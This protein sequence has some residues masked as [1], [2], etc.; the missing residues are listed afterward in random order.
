MLLDADTPLFS[1]ELARPL[2]LLSLAV[3]IGLLIAGSEYLPSS[4]WDVPLCFV[5]GI[6]AYVFAPW[7]FRQ[8]Y[9]FRWW[10][11]LPAAIAL[12]LT[13]DGSYTLYWWLKDFD[14]LSAF[15]PANYFYC[16]WLFWACGVV[17]NIDYAKFR[18]FDT[19]V[20][21]T[22]L[23]AKPKVGRKSPF[24]GFVC[25]A[26]LAAMISVQLAAI[27]FYRDYILLA[28]VFL[29]TAVV[30]GANYVEHEK[31]K[32][33]GLPKD[34]DSDGGIDYEEKSSSGCEYEV[35]GDFVLLIPN[36]AV[37]EV[38][39]LCEKFAEAGIR[40]QPGRYDHQQ[41]FSRFGRGGL[42]SRMYVWVH[43]D[44]VARARPIAER[45]L[46]VEV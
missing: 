26:F 8:V 25:A 15:R 41:A 44:D 30:L 34:F 22:N 39:P 33:P 24:L 19:S 40:F 32:E 45:L 38:D 21:M 10:K 2:R 12:W 4:D 9:Y 5:M 29:V 16:I 1:R 18:W 17:F 43:K 31:K 28:I 42:D 7:A 37:Y 14:A 13:I 27:L 46:K 11:L 3:G 6:P 35:S 20:D 36:V 23:T